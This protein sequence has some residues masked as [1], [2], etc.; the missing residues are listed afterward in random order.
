MEG[1]M[2]KGLSSAAMAGLGGVPTA[3]SWRRLPAGPAPAECR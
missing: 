3:R 2:P 1:S